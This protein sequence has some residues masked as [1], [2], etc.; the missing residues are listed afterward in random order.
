MRIEVLGDGPPEV[1][2]IGG[3]HGD[4]PCG[5]DA[6]EHVLADP[7][8]VQRPVALVI[9][10]EEA[11]AAGVRYLDEDLNRAFPGD[12]EA[13]THEGRLAARLRDELGQC[14]TLSLHST[15]SFGE[16]F[17]IVNTMDDFVR[18]VAPQL[19]ITA[20][21]D[22]SDFDAGRLFEAVLQTIEVECGFQGTAAAAANA[23]EV[24]RAFLVATGVLPDDAIPEAERWP[25]TDID[26]FRLEDRVPK[27][28]AETHDVYV[29][30]F[31]KVPAGTAFAAADGEP[32]HAAD[33]FYP[34]LMS[35]EGYEELFG[36]TASFAGTLP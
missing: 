19:P 24:T 1:A 26:V 12:H 21:V 28:A 9:A 30:N 32:V 33:D 35:A 16:P 2:V 29:A 7:P 23:V 34:V 27:R 4:E 3:I 31:D 36:Y 11:L 22:A 25:R 13:E 15:Q 20:V 14:E 18:H 5:R 17:A 6:V 10:N 8:D